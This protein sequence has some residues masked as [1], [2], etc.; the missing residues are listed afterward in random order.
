MNPSDGRSPPRTARSAGLCLMMLLLIGCVSV[1]APLPN[2]TAGA[3][4]ES[5]QPEVPPDIAAALAEE[6]RLSH[7]IELAVTRS[8][9]IE[10]ARSEWLAS[11]YV[12]PQAA[13][14]PDPVLQLG[15]QFES[16]ETR[17]GPQ[18]W[19][20]GLMQTIPWW[21]KLWARSRLAALRADVAQL[22]YEF[23]IRQVLQ[24]VRDSYYELYYIDGA[25][26][27]TRGIEQ[28]LTTEALLAYQ[29]MAVG[30][31]QL[32][33]AFRAESWKAQLEFDRFFLEEQRVAQAERLRGLL[34][35]PPDTA[36]GPVNLAPAY[37]FD[38]ALED[39]IARAELYSETLR[40]RGLEIEQARYQTYLAE[41]SRIPDVTLGVNVIQ[42]SQG[43]RTPMG[44]R[45]EG[46]GQNP[47]I[48]MLS[49]NL[50]I[51][52]WRNR[53]LIRERE[54]M[55]AAAFQRGLEE[56]NAL[57]TAVAAGWFRSRLADRTVELYAETLVPQAEAIMRQ[58]EIYFR[59]DQASLS[60]LIE[61]T[62]AYH[63]FE[64]AHRRAIADRGQAIARL[65]LAI[66]AMATGAVQPAGTTEQ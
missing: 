27:I 14:P 13:T 1:P 44:E 2:D 32:N 9:R 60:N 25:I 18:R 16:V 54:A 45:P 17:V 57:R 64:L 51:W 7:A 15:Y 37:P 65:E 29:E 40:I 52:E 8:P 21:R 22:R 41:L 26:E 3:L 62:I 24:E 33:E 50:P 55:E 36:I 43:M 58:A 28:L 6:P 59:S 31:T 34:N 4:R 66:G 35:L 30:R 23:S 63:N 53:A 5:L 42:T 46:S 38:L 47:V 11:I 12:E 48:G 61:S 10:A 56:A 49:M 39:L 20:A 19:N